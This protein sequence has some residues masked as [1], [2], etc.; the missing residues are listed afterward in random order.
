MASRIMHL[1]IADGIS[2]KIDIQDFNLFKLG[3]ILPDAYSSELNTANSHFKTKILNGSKITYRLA[4]FRETYTNELLNNSLYT[5]YYLHLI[6]DIL[7]RQFVYD[8]YKWNPALEGNVGRLHNDYRLLNT[9]LIQKYRITNEIYFPNV[10]ENERL[11]EIYPF[12]LKQL[13]SDL[14]NDF[15][16]YNDDSTFFFT[17]SMSDEYIERA[18]SKCVKEIIS[19]RNG[20]YVIDEEKYAWST[21]HR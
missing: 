20:N 14:Q 2:K 6:Q 18:I 8:D 9:Y 12:D 3:S 19:L 10:I 17:K 1:A 5:G 11:F 13:K 4:F 16:P 15:I 7:Y 21:H